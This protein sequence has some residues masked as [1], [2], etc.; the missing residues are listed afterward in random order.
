MIKNTENKHNLLA[1]ILCI[2]SILGMHSF[3][4][5]KVLGITLTAYRV[6]IP[7]MIVYYLFLILYKEKNTIWSDFVEKKFILSV[8]FICTIWIIYGLIQILLAKE[9]N[10]RES[11]QEIYMLSLGFFSMAII[12]AMHLYGVK[13]QIFLY[14]IKVIYIAL[15]VFSIYEIVSGNHLATSKLQ[16]LSNDNYEAYKYLSSTI[17]YNVNDYSAFLAIFSPIFFGGEKVR[18]KFLNLIIVFLSVSILLKNDAWICFFAVVV[19][20]LIYI[21]LNY[22]KNNFN[23]NI[24]DGSL[25]LIAVFCGYKFGR[26][27]FNIIKMKEESVENELGSIETDDIN[28]GIDDIVQEIAPPSTVTEPSIGQVI[29]SQFGE[30]AVNSSGN[31]RID[32][33]CESI[34]N[35]FEDTFGLG[36]GPANFNQYL[37]N[38]DNTNLLVNPHSLWVE[39]F[40]QYGLIIFIL[41]I[42]ALLFLYICL[43]RIYLKNKNKTVLCVI[44]MAATYVLASFAPSTFLTYPYQ[45]ILIGISISIVMKYNH[46]IL[47]KEES[48]K[49]DREFGKNKLW[50]K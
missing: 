47:K 40:V 45:W 7:I 29:T 5:I 9:I 35:M 12:I 18:T 23:K 36:Y 31:I 44:S 11:F 14:T 34:G 46:L 8:I 39:I 49:H 30:N 6:M 26:Q 4:H 48:K 20:L 38:S 50:K 43:I 16:E 13:A 27:I 32:T 33:Y 10:Y 1:I 41:F 21:L 22:K 37:S 28:Q 2:L 42:A 24:I 3:L 15:I 17:F 25:T 19:S